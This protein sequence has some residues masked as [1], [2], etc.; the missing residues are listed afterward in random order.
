MPDLAFQ[1]DAAA[2]PGAQGDHGHVWDAA[3]STQPLLTERSNVSVIFQ[4][5]SRPQAPFDFRAH[6]ILFPTRKVRR[7]AKRSGL[8]ID[9]ARDANAGAEKLPCL[10]ILG[11][12]TLDGI[13]HFRDHVVATQSNF[14]AERNLLEEL[15]IAAH[16]CNAQVGA[17]QVDPDGKIRHDEKE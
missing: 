6:R 5:H 9:D 17:A 16:G 13:A 8:H 11:R 15:P 7:F 3:G 1:Y 2:N 10:F 12:E 14:G 4:H